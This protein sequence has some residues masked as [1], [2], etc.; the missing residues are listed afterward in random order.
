MKVTM[1]SV[2]VGISSFLINYF[3]SEDFVT[4]YCSNFFVKASIEE[5]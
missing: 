2:D 5:Y 4:P 3:Q 1:Y